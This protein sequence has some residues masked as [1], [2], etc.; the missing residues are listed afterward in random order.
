MFRQG[1]EAF[2]V[3]PTPELPVLLSRARASMWE[4]KDSELTSERMEP[5]CVEPYVLPLRPDE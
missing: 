4:V 5:T 3:P 2:S 1:P